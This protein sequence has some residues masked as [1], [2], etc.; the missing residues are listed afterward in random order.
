MSAFGVDSGQGLG[1]GCS[2]SVSLSLFL[3]NVPDTHV[4]VP[5]AHWRVEPRQ[6]ILDVD[7]SPSKLVTRTDD[8]TRS[9][10]LGV[11]LVRTTG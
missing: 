2:L 7:Q 10:Q 3:P 1:E 11:V 8:R 6:Q 5:G 9:M 4:D